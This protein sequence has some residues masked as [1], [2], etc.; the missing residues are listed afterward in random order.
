M[1][2]AYLRCIRA[3]QDPERRREYREQPL[4]FG[5]SKTTDLFFSAE[6]SAEVFALQ[7]E[8][9][10]LNAAEDAGRAHLERALYHLDSTAARIAT[11]AT[12]FELAAELDAPDAD[13]LAALEILLRET[14]RS[15]SAARD[16]RRM[17]A[18]AGSLAAAFEGAG[19][20]SVLA[21]AGPAGR[22]F[23]DAWQARI[24]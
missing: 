24:Q 22:T 11:A 18:W 3:S 15:P 12:Y 23:K 20:P 16:V 21:E 5:S 6:L 19:L 2:A 10:L 9:G 8:R 7:A 17:Q 4:V 13:L 14:N 1:T